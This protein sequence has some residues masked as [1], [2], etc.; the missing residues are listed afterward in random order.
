MTT[1]T[2]TNKRE[3]DKKKTAVL[4]VIEVAR[5]EFG[6][7]GYLITYDH[8]ASE[9]NAHKKIK[10]GDGGVS[11]YEARR[12]CNEDSVLFGGA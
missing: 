5:K 3:V 1:T 6:E 9:W 7:N 2:K 4:K 12:G 10:K 11:A 8:N